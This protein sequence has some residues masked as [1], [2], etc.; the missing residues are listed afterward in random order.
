MQLIDTC[1][2]AVGGVCEVSKVHMADFSLRT[3]TR[4]A[5]LAKLMSI[6]ATCPTEQHVVKQLTRVHVHTQ[7]RQVLV[8]T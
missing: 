7:T 6:L 4:L 3:S 2:C 8:D 5:V 1:G